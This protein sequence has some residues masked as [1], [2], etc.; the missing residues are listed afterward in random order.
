M[1]KQNKIRKNINKY[2]IKYIH[3]KIGNYIIKI[4]IK[5]ILKK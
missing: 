1:E 5:I 3:I 4:E 2:K